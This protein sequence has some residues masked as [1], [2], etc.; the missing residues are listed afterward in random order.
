MK[1]N[2]TVFEELAQFK[3]S[4]NDCITVLI[5]TSRV[6]DGQAEKIIFKN[7][8]DEALKLL[9]DEEIQQQPLGKKATLKY[10]SSAYSLLDDE[11]FWNHQSDGLAV[12]IGPNIF[13]YYSLPVSFRPLTYVNKHFYLFP[14][15]EAITGK[16]R[17]FLLAL[18]QNEVRFFEGNKYSITPV[19]IHDLVPD[20]LEA[21]LVGDTQSQ[22][23]QA[24]SGGGNAVF[25]GQGGSKDDKLKHLEN[26]F[27]Q[28]DKGLMEMLHDEDAPMLIASVDYLLPI[29]QSISAYS[30]IVEASISGNPESDDPVLLHERAW[31]L[32]QNLVDQQTD[33]W[34]EEFGQALADKKASFKA[35]EIVPA[36][37]QGKIDTLF[38]SKEAK[39]VWGIQEETKN[40]THLDTAQ[41]KNN[42]CLINDAAVNTYLKGGKI[43]LEESNNLPNEEGILQAI[44][45]Y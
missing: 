17:F 29:Y 21:T 39:P 34:K 8:L 22:E 32:I 11:V 15:L 13:E 20:N 43:T 40:T 10:L 28:I 27:R 6:S 36:A 4:D 18:S 30:N 42:Y 26:Y 38:I 41:Y 31:P 2:K 37:R 7:Q 45:R 33:Q 14:T 23:L 5:P 19:I 35:A 24:H 25:H 12:F 3:S 1:F 9:M 44:F 16:K